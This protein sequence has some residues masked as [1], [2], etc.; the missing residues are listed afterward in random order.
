MDALKKTVAGSFEEARER[1]IAELAKEGFG[2]LTRIDVKD[3][4]SKKIGVD[5]RRYEILGA[6]NPRLAHRALTESLEVGTLLPCNVIVY[7]DDEGRAV[8]WAV[9]P[10]AMLPGDAA[11]LRAVADEARE[12]LS[13]AV[14]AV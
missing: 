14:A 9:D 6:C 12:R 11:G 13:R 2:V 7:E 3:T 4:L 5:F 10:S 8:V 1:V